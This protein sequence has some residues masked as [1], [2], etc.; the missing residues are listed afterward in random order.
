MGALGCQGKTLT[1]LRHHLLLLALSLAPPSLL[2]F[3]GPEERP[4][5]G[6]EL[7][8]EGWRR[9][10]GRGGVFGIRL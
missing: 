4:R 5:G 7:E 10:K 3:P 8:G 1:E 9:E 2:L 6:L